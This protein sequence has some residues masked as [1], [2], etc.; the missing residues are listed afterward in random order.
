ME[1]GKGNKHFDI[2][3][4]DSYIYIY[5]DFKAKLIKS[6]INKYKINN[7]SFPYFHKNIPMAAMFK[8]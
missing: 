7:V 6:K 5:M 3:S 4:M 1:I 8:T 2:N